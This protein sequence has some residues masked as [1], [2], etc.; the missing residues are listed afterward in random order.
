MIFRV[1]TLMTNHVFLEYLIFLKKSRF[2]EIDAPA[3]VQASLLKDQGRF[4][5]SPEPTKI[6]KKVTSGPS[7]KHSFQ[8]T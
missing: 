6:E 1:Q 8:K 5:M 7:K 2:F 4:W 3:L